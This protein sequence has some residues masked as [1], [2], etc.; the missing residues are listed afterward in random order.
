MSSYEIITTLVALAQTSAALGTRH[1]ELGTINVACHGSDRYE[2]WVAFR[3]KNFAPLSPVRRNWSV[4]PGAEAWSCSGRIRVAAR[5]GAMASKAPTPTRILLTTDLWKLPV[6][7]QEANAPA[8]FNSMG[9][10]Q[11]HWGEGRVVTGELGSGG[12]EKEEEG[13]TTPST[14]RQRC[15]NVQMY[16]TCPD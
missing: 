4:S 16:R 5:A 2:R 8:K 1:V 3:W 15:T 7:R 10:T 11:H 14:N 9:R 13:P 12:R 6:A